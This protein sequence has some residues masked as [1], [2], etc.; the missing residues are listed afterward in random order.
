MKIRTF[1]L[2]IF[3]LLHVL[4]LVHADASNSDVNLL[5]L[6]TKLANALGIPQ[7]AGQILVCAIFMLMFMLPVAIYSKTLLPPLF[8]GILVLAFLIAVGWLDF[9]FL[10]V[11]CLFISLMFAGAMR[12]FIT[13]K[14]RG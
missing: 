8:V 14:G 6:P 4:P 3:G 2:F 11:I 1:N 10:L 5:D 9:W 12:D 13:G 7:F